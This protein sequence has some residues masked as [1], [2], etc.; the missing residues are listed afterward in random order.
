MVGKIATAAATGPAP[1][2]RMTAT[3][4]ADASDMRKAAD[5]GDL[6]RASATADTLAER[7]ALAQRLAQLLRHQR[8]HAGHQAGSSPPLG[9]HG[10]VVVA[11]ETAASLGRAPGMPALAAAAEAS[12]LG[13]F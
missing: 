4:P 12:V 2:P 6:A 10:A 9:P 7:E 11:R 8:D 3:P 1:E 5:L 13:L